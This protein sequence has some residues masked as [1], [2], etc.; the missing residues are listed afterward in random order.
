MSNALRFGILIGGAVLI[1]GA[2]NF[3]IVEKETLLRT[4]QPVL[5]ELAPVDPRSLM[6]GDYM[7]LRY[8][9]ARHA[10]GQGKALPRRGRMV[11]ALDER[12]VASFQRLYA[13]GDQ[14]RANERLLE[15]R[16]NPASWRRSEVRLG[17]ES[18][19][20]Q[21]G[22][23]NIYDDARYGELRVAEDG[24]SVLVGLRGENLEILGERTLAIDAS[25]VV[26]HSDAKDGAE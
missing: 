23:A 9:I 15:F 11:V 12:N 8:E 24:S 21:E 3:A 2:M 19:F 4:G 5:L 18:F 16:R 13:D 10:V 14:L 20:F 22:T 6:Q 26:Y 17:A 7:R 1:L 25:G